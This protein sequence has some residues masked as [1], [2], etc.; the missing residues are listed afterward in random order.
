MLACTF[1]PNF[2]WWAW[3]WVAWGAVGLG[4]GLECTD[5]C[6]GRSTA[7]RSDL[8]ASTPGSSPCQWESVRLSVPPD[9]KAHIKGI[10]PPCAK[11]R[12]A[13]YDCV[14]VHT[15]VCTCTVPHICKECTAPSHA[16]VWPVASLVAGYGSLDV[17]VRIRRAETLVRLPVYH[18]TGLLLLLPLSTARHEE[19]ENQ[20]ADKTDQ[21]DLETRIHGVQSAIYAYAR[22]RGGS[23]L[24]KCKN[25]YAATIYHYVFA[26][27]RAAGT[28]R[29]VLTPSIVYHVSPP[30]SLLSRY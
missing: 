14:K 1:P 13:A 30:A 7:G 20:A 4:L 11:R 8:A 22:A 6:N 17:D 21:R 25:T 9:P 27:R 29:C 18:S 24:Q 19:Q 26:Q 23:E 12:H 16:S 15:Y 28:P 10:L 3:V 5:P 2:D